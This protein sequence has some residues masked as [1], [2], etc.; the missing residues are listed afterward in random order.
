MVA[1]YLYRFGYF[2]SI[3]DRQIGNKDLETEIA[4]RL[5]ETFWA[6]SVEKPWGKGEWYPQRK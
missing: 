3:L 1:N 5:A 6:L 4:R 2:V